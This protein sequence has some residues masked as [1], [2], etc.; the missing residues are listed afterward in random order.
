MENKN[1]KIKLFALI[2]FSNVCAFILGGLDNSKLEDEIIST[3]VSLERPN[4]SRIRIMA[5]LR[6]EL[7]FDKPLIITNKSRTLYIPNVFVI[8]EDINHNQAEFGTHELQQEYYI[9][10]VPNDY[11]KKLFASKN[12]EILPLIKKENIVIQKNQRKKYEITI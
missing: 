12:L 4:H 1:L 5:N 10:S 9:V 7:S 11:L 8:K 3:H 6:A 2:I